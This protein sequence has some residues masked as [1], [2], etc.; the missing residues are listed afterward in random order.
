MMDCCA[1]EQRVVVTNQDAYPVTV[2]VGDDKG[3]SKPAAYE[4]RAAVLDGETG[5]YVPTTTSLCV[6]KSDSPL[7]IAYTHGNK[8]THRVFAYKEWS[9]GV[10]F[11]YTI[12]PW[13]ASDPAEVCRVPPTV[14]GNRN[15]RDANTEDDEAPGNTNEAWWRWFWRR[16]GMRKMCISHAAA[17]AF[18]ALVLVVALAWYILS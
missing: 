5:V 14:N 16:Q 6:P 13:N 7:S 9:N 12:P 1:N 4:A 11:A 3:F 17:M 2:R 8:C 18:A 15:L 10:K